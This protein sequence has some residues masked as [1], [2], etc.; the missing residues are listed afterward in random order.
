M[1]KEVEE[2]RCVRCPTALGKREEKSKLL[3]HDLQEKSLN[4][5]LFYIQVPDKY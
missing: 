5:F 1:Q 2:L 3:C 4:Y